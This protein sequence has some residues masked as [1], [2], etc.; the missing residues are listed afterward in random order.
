M[1][2]DVADRFSLE[3]ANPWGYPR[4]RHTLPFRGGWLGFRGPDRPARLGLVASASIEETFGMLSKMFKVVAVAA[5]IGGTVE[6]GAVSSVHVSSPTQYHNPLPLGQAR[7]KVSGS[8][9]QGYF[10]TGTS[11]AWRLAPAQ[12]AD[13]ALV[14]QDRIHSTGA[15]AEIQARIDTLSRQLCRMGS[16]SAKRVLTGTQM[17]LL[18]DYLNR[19][20]AGEVDDPAAPARNLSSAELASVAMPNGW[21]LQFKGPSNIVM[22]DPKTGYGVRFH[23]D[24]HGNRLSPDGSEVHYMEWNSQMLTA[25]IGP[26]VV[27]MH[28]NGQG[29][30]FGYVDWMLAM[31]GNQYL[32]VKGLDG[33]PSGCA[34]E[35]A[36]PAFE[37]YRNLIEASS[38]VTWVESEHELRLADGSRMDAPAGAENGYTVRRPASVVSPAEFF[39]QLRFVQ[40]D[41]LSDIPGDVREIGARFRQCKAAETSTDPLIQQAGTAQG[42]RL[43]ENAKLQKSGLDERRNLMNEASALAKEL[44]EIQAEMMLPGISPRRMKE[45]AEQ[46]K[47]KE[48]KLTPLVEKAEA[49]EKSAR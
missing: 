8:R 1:V 36:L 44:V 4:L 48:A 33:T 6:A 40:A 45:L 11:A 46:A 31:N 19:I 15:I 20:I 17:N 12:G 30:H 23:N 21:V 43:C 14:T 10:S 29:G 26:M 25:M 13:G 9:T 24:P 28:A 5:C 41:S 47:E 37:A 18:S 16:G 7:V 49:L 22:L 39:A 3:L 27:F 32:L 34:G 38:I 42:I 35:G 2:I